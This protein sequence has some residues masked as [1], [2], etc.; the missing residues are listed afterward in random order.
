MIALV[1]NAYRGI[2]CSINIFNK[3]LSFIMISM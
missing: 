3:L 2:R 1:K